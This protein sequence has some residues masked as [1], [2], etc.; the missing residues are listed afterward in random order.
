MTILVVCLVH[1]DFAI[2]ILRLYTPVGIS[3]ARICIS[4][5]RL[6]FFIP[7]NCG[8]RFIPEFQFTQPDL[9]ISPS[10]LN[11]V[12]F[13]SELSLAVTLSSRSWSFIYDIFIFDLIE[14]S[15]SKM[16]GDDSFSIISLLTG[17]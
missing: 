5:I 1:S 11:D 3:T 7:P 16:L 17:C 6:V 4:R 9:P 8:N 12:F 13:Y 2:P 15:Q 10:V 14:I